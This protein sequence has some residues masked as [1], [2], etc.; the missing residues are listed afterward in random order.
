MVGV[1]EAI[2]K[3]NQFLSGFLKRNLDDNFSLNKAMTDL[4]DFLATDEE[5]C[6]IFEDDLECKHSPAKVHGAVKQ[7]IHD[8]PEDWDIINMGSCWRK[9]HKD[10]YVTENLVKAEGALCRHGYLVNRKGAQKVLQGTLPMRNKPGDK[11]IIDM[12]SDINIYASSPRLFEQRRDD[13]D[14]FTS[15]LENGK[16]PPAEC[17]KRYR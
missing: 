17:A 13:T 1:R 2:T 16:A 14:T 10:E 7:H 11:S 12:G 5:V 9:C 4:S 8:V 3:K 6:L 15:N